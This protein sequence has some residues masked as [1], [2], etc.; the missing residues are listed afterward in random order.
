MFSFFFFSFVF[1]FR[2][3][4]RW[5]SRH[6]NLRCSLL[7]LTVVHAAAA[8]A[9]TVAKHSNNSN[10]TDKNSN[11]T[12]QK[13]ISATTNGDTGSSRRQTR[14][15][16]V[17]MAGYRN[18][19]HPRRQLLQV[20][21]SAVLAAA[22]GAAAT[23]LPLPPYDGV[24]G[25][26]W[27]HNYPTTGLFRCPVPVKIRGAI[28]CL[29]VEAAETGRVAVLPATYCGPDQLDGHAWS[30]AKT[31]N[32]AGE[33]KQRPITDLINIAALQTVGMALLPAAFGARARPKPAPRL[34]SSASAAVYERGQFRDG[35]ITKTEFARWDHVK[36]MQKSQANLIVRSLHEG[37][38]SMQCDGD[39]K[40]RESRA[41]V[42]PA[43]A[44]LPEH[45]ASLAAKAKAAML[46][47]LPEG[48]PYCALFLSDTSG[49]LRV[50]PSVE[51]LATKLSTR[52]DAPW[53][54]KSFRLCKAVWIADTSAPPLH[55]LWTE[56]VRKGHS[57]AE[58]QPHWQ[59]QSLSEV[60]VASSTSAGG[61]SSSSVHAELDPYQKLAVDEYMLSEAAAVAEVIPQKNTDKSQQ[62][63]FK[64]TYRQVE[65]RPPVFQATTKEE[66]IEQLKLPP[67][68]AHDIKHPDVKRAETI[69]IKIAA[70]NSRLG[71]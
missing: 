56:V 41:R 27:E 13:R 66:I 57:T 69:A 47:G 60:L 8:P 42:L 12:N 65:A 4:P 51:L 1:L 40:Y 20:S 34:D 67:G 53:K 15:T 36:E 39:P 62:P 54:L 38:A 7:F 35:R 55:K 22:G 17:S 33:E 10:S 24:G 58:D 26:R 59:T 50:W 29:M 16:S 25:I 46:A 71:V 2:G 63:S 64:Y 70:A 49:R 3:M 19:T 18:Q 11:V 6:C 52:V 9:I 43:L 23:F 68:Q 21:R 44:T 5:L 48:T 61:A 14:A 30:S 32:P 31:K 45:L 28:A 37:Q